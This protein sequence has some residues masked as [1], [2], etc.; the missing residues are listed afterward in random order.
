[1]KNVLYVP[2]AY[3]NLF[4]V[5]STLNKDMLNHLKMNMNSQGTVLSRHETFELL[6]CL[7]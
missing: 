2:I 4:L 1:M 3:R 5:T 6:N 7:K